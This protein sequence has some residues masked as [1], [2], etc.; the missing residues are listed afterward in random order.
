MKR[1]AIVVVILLIAVSRIAMMGCGHRPMVMRMQPAPSGATV[2]VN[3][4]SGVYHYP[5]DRYYGNTRDGAFMTEAQAQAQGYRP[6]GH[7]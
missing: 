5:G 1:A 2:W 6:A 4:R 7:R 3:A